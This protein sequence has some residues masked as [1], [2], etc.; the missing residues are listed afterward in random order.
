MPH[1]TDAFGK[2]DYIPFSDISQTVCAIF[3]VLI[4][5]VGITG[6]ILS[7]KDASPTVDGILNILVILHPATNPMLLYFYDPI[8]GQFVKEL[9]LVKILKKRFCKSSRGQIVLPS[10]QSI[11]SPGIIGKNMNQ[12][13]Q[14]ELSKNSMFI[15]GSLSK[16]SDH[17]VN[18][19]RNEK[20]SAIASESMHDLVELNLAHSLPRI[21]LEDSN[22]LNPQGVPYNVTGANH[23]NH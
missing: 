13:V 14:L 22:A 4:A 16:P 5:P 17:L 6:Q 7:G 18:I 8:I 12:S 19:S 21:I 9:K 2:G 20:I 23:T 3:I 1:A 15:A 11:A 10:N